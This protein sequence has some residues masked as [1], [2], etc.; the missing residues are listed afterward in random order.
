MAIRFTETGG[1]KAFADRIVELA[2]SIWVVMKPFALLIKA[3]ATV[4]MRAPGLLAAIIGIQAALA[5]F[6]LNPIIAGLTAVIALF[7]ALKKASDDAA[8][9]VWNSA[10]A[11]QLA[12]KIAEENEKTLESLQKEQDSLV[13]SI[14]KL[15]QE[16]DEYITS[17]KKLP[18]TEQEAAFITENLN[19]KMAEQVERLNEVDAQIIKVSE[20]LGTQNENA[21]EAANA[22]SGMARVLTKLRG[23][24]DFTKNVVVSFASAEEITAEQTEALSLKIAE[25][26][27]K[28]DELGK[29]LLAMQGMFDELRGLLKELRDEDLESMKELAAA[30]ASCN[31]I[32]SNSA[33]SS[34]RVILFSRYSSSNV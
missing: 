13:E 22:A 27:V 23:E 34:A 2:K 21:L 28:T 19:R 20:D 32:S 25:L 31:L 18:L 7:A 30:N 4:I 1:A 6:N 26:T 10:K 12:A 24:L 16:M 11:Q 5:L 14:V 17:S 15:R 29:K 33:I 3:I 8:A 9:A